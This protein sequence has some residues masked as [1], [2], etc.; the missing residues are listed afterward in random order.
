M[1]LV[2]NINGTSSNRCK[3]G[4]WLTHWENYSGAPAIFCSVI[5]CN[6]SASVGAHVQKANSLV[7]KWYIVPMCQF[8]NFSSG[9]LE[10][11]PPLVSANVNETCGR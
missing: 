1:T 10:V 2:K 6:N 9:E 7:D 3:C 5:G 4:N 11:S 8:H